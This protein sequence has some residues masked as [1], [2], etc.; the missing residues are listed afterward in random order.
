MTFRTMSPPVKESGHTL[1]WT[2]GEPPDDDLILCLDFGTSFSKASA[3][4]TKQEDD[5]PEIIDIVFD[6]EAEGTSRFLLPSELFIHDEHVYL[7]KSARKQFETVDAIQDRLID[8]PKQYMTLGT[9]VADLRQKPL[10]PEQDP[11]QSLSQRDALVLYLS[12]LNHLAEKS[13]KIGDAVADVRRRFAHP[14][15]D[16]TSAAAN[17]KAMARIMVESIVLA[18]NYPHEFEQGMPL[19]L[20]RDLIRNAQVLEDEDLPFALLVAFGTRGYC[21]GSRCIDGNSGAWKAVL[22]DP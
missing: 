19:A 14:A 13:L 7:G 12:H 18:R 17:S 21:R 10:R 16:E 8:S 22:R 20:A 4:R 15:W 3:C 6:E 2:P 11:S 9:E 5:I 1:R